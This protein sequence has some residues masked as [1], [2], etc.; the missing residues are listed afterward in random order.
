[1]GMTDRNNGSTNSRA[2]SRCRGREYRMVSA[3]RGRENIWASS[4]HT[5]ALKKT[6]QM[7]GRCWGGVNNVRHI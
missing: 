6:T 2:A 7:E 1:M 4:N 3:D 5:G